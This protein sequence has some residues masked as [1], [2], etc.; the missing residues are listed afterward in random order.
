MTRLLD[1]AYHQSNTWDD[2]MRLTELLHEK[3]WFERPGKNSMLTKDP[4]CAWFSAGRTDIDQR[5]KHLPALHKDVLRTTVKK[6]IEVHFYLPV[7]G[8]TPEDDKHVNF[9]EP[10]VAFVWGD[11]TLKHQPVIPA[12]T[13]LGRFIFTY[14]W[15]HQH[16]LFRYFLSRNFNRYLNQVILTGI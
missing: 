16:D 12:F 7:A 2:V 4:A 1:P 6:W 3:G 9:M 10:F 11:Y 13:D 14:I 8:L 5:S 15:I